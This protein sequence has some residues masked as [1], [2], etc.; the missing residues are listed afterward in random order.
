MKRAKN[1]FLPL[2]LTFGSNECSVRHQG[3]PNRTAGLL[4]PYSGFKK[5]KYHK[6]KFWI[7]E[8]SARTKQRWITV[9]QWTVGKE[10]GTNCIRITMNVASSYRLSILSDKSLFPLPA[11]SVALSVNSPQARR[12][13]S[14][15]CQTIVGSWQI[16][17]LC[18]PSPDCLHFQIQLLYIPS[19][20]SLH[21]QL[22]NW[23]RHFAIGNTPT[24]HKQNYRS[25]HLISNGVFVAIRQ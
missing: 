15:K 5:I 7:H 18:I 17:L 21:F 1:L 2:L 19:P 4:S 25:Q 14:Q 12:S 3:A 16:Q 6:Y 22:P 24:L 13:S 23:I 8:Q 10:T 20:D 11:D 9:Y